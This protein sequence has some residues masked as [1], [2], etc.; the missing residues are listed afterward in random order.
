ML[1]ASKTSPY[2]ACCEFKASHCSFLSII[3][4]ANAWREMT[5]R[6]TARGAYLCIEKRGFSPFLMSFIREGGL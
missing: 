6:V 2:R 5:E 4:L 3:Y 1:S